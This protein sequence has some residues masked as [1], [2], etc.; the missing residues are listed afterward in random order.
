MEVKKFNTRCAKMQMGKQVPPGT[1]GKLEY[2]STL[3]HPKS[4]KTRVVF[5]L[6]SLHWLKVFNSEN[7]C[8]HRKPSIKDLQVLRVGNYMTVYVH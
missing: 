3:L 2:G 8:H 6:T 7:F 5:T 4:D 1:P